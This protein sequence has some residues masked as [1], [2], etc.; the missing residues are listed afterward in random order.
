MRARLAVVHV[1]D[2]DGDDDGEADQDHG[3]E[4]V[5]A[6][7]RQGERSRRDDLGDEEEEHGLGEQ[8]VDAEGDLFTGVGGEV[9]H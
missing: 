7:E 9:E 5:L 3:E 1:Q 4:D 8:D 6:E 2:D